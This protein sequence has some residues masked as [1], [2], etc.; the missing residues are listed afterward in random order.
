MS[1]ALTKDG[2]VLAV[3]DLWTRP[4]HGTEVVVIDLL[5]VGRHELAPPLLSDLALHLILV[6][7]GGGVELGEVGLEVFEYVVVHLGEA[8]RGALH[9]LEDGPVRLKMLHGCNRLSLVSEQHRGYHDIETN[10]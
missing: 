7:G 5:L 3:L 6:N 4:Q 10:P 2:G 1:G 8:Q 9:L